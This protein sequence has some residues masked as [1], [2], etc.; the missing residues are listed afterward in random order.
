VRIFFKG[1][2]I[3]ISISGLALI[4]YLLTIKIGFV[5]E[6]IPISGTGSMYPTFPKGEG[7][8]SASLSRQ[9]VS[10]PLMKRFPRGISIGS[11][12]LFNYSLQRNDIVS[13]ENDRTRQITIDNNGESAGF[14]KRII[15][16]PGE[17]VEIRDGFVLIN[18]QKLVE[19]FTAVPRSTFGGKSLPDCQKL[20]IPEGQVF[21]L[22]DNRKASDDSRHDVGL[23][24]ISDIDHVIPFADQSAFRKLWRDASK[25]YLLADHPTLNTSQY[26]ELLN[27][28]R[29]E[30]NLSALKHQSK[31]DASA[32]KRASIILRYNDLSFEATRSGITMEK[33]MAETGYSNTTWG[34][35]PTIGFY[36]AQELIDNF[37]QFRGSR[38]FLL[39]ADFQDTGL[40]VQTGEI[41]GC[42]V[43]VVVQHLAGY[44][45]PN[46]KKEV[47]DSWKNA[48]DQLKKVQPGWNIAKSSPQFYSLNQK[49]IDEI[50]D[51]IDLRV[52]H[53]EAIVSRMQ[54]NQW[55]SAEEKSWYESDEELA[56]K[57]EQ[58][59]KK[60]NTP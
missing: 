15:G 25:D 57:L 24:S 39:N 40:S 48:L 9:I 35:A 52:R 49:D 13:F 8:E 7:T 18:G 42:P 53:L 6:R 12:H 4:G 3:L 47:I 26:L 45:P 38:D 10:A 5:P 58:L 46:Y 54:A 31:L 50:S 22:G 60:V 59:T 16:L 43:Q 19:D 44:V 27:Q 41:N 21:V 14:V 20:K 17:T 11:F 23:I 56:R 37:F 32:Q 2:S 28:K 29:R 33:T 51:L 30:N 1:I 55:L 36:T 34:E